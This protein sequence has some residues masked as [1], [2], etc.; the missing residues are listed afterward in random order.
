MGQQIYPCHRSEVCSPTLACQ[1]GLICTDQ[2]EC[3]SHSN[4]PQKEGTY[5]GI[6][7]H[8]LNGTKNKGMRG[9][10]SVPT[11]G[12]ENYTEGSTEAVHPVAPGMLSHITCLKG[13]V[14]DTSDGI[15]SFV[16][17]VTVL[18]STSGN[19][20]L[21]PKDVRVSGFCRPGRLHRCWENK[22]G[23]VL[24]TLTCI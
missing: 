11:T 16:R 19:Y 22:K 6:P 4:L 20:E 10:S 21:V 24:P 17:L 23:Y 5:N 12:Q 15:R 7:T 9:Y 1:R 14:L 2:N 18:N 8:A 3:L 13:F